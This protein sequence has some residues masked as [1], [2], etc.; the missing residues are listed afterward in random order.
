MLENGGAADERQTTGLS[1][2]PGPDVFGT[3]TSGPYW[4]YA[5]NEEI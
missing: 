3:N 1:K 2:R 4:T 5:G